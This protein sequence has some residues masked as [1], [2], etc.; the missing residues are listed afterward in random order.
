[1]QDAGDSG[2]GTITDPSPSMQKDDGRSKVLERV[3]HTVT[4]RD[5]LIGAGAGAVTAGAVLSGAVVVSGVG[6]PTTTKSNAPGGP[7]P[8]AVSPTS[9]RVVLNIDGAA[10]EVIVDNRESLWDTMTY[11][12]G[13][14]AS[15]TGCDRAQCG[16]CTVLIDGKAVNSCTIQSSRLGRGQQIKTVASLATGAGVAGLHPVQRSFWLNGGFQCGICTK[17]FIMSTVAL[18]AAVP[19]PTNAQISEALS[20]NICRCGEYSKIF[21]AVN[22]AA[23]EMAGEKVT[24][25]AAPVVVEAA[26]PAASPA[27][28]V[29]GTSKAFEFATPLATI[30][31]FDPVATQVKAK[32]GILDVSGSERTITIKWDPA[33]LDEQKVRDILTAL[34]HP[35]K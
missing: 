7:A 9:R 31:D 8:K 35:L 28:T 17:G 11:T 19:K 21:T 30:E 12:L 20:G 32:D 10:Q 27:P 5:F 6:S 4:R 29:T 13:M 1:M 23:S 2:Q 18:L 16:A 14:S 22:G 15:N 25:L 34:G 26:K 3:K 24:Y 33:K